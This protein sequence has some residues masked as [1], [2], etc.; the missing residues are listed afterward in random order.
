[1][2]GLL[3]CV[4][5]ALLLAAGALAGTA[6]A[7]GDPA[8]DVLLNYPAFVPSD[9][10]IGA[11][12]A[13]ARLTSVLDAAARQRFPIRVAIIASQSDLGSVTPLWSEPVA[14]ARFLGIEL[15]FVYR[16]QVLVV[17]PAGL[18]LYSSSAIP[19]AERAAL[20]AMPSPRSSARLLLAALATVRGL[21]AATGHP[22]S[23]S[24]IAASAPAAPPA[25]TD[26]L[27]WLAFAAGALLVALAWA[28]SLR[29][30]PLR[31]GR[32][33]SPAAS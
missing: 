30:R 18:G 23:G 4:A 27:A 29:A 11:I 21:A 9:L 10:G 20:S 32:T 25:S 8:S 22:L 17:M 26:L 31:A 12:G 3:A 28:A 1:M 7:D 33:T 13:E 14:Y 15:S 24:L 16:G 6:R 2:R 5:A 19:A